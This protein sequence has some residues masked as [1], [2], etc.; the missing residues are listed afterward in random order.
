MIEHR[1]WIGPDYRRGID[2]QRVM[3]VGYSHYLREDTDQDG[4]TEDIINRITIKRET[5]GAFFTAIPK[6][7][8]FDDRVEFWNRVMFFNFIPECVGSKEKKFANGTS[9][10]VERARE[11]FVRLIRDAKPKPDRVLVL[12]TKGWR[13]CQQ[14]LREAGAEQCAATCNEAES[15]LHYR[16]NV[17]GHTTRIL[18]LRHPQGAKNAQMAES[19]RSF[20][21]EGYGA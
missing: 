20:L 19:V 5:W 1:P 8:D 3:I 10:Q 11:R 6:Y 16:Y 21:M 7:F 2:G 4:A 9:G 17:N 12:T 18:G 15:P 13:H 14:A